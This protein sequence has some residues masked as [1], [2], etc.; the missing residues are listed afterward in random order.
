MSEEIEA[1]TL[2]LPESMLMWRKFGAWGNV[3][4]TRTC[5]PIVMQNQ[6]VRSR[7]AD[8]NGIVSG[9]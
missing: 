1:A 3:D 9:C 6:Q 8:F 5:C 7:I 4:S 2:A